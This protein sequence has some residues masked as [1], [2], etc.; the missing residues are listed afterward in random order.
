MT[1]ERAQAAA[2]H[3]VTDPV[4]MRRWLA[5]VPVTREFPPDLTAT[6]R[7]HSSLYVIEMSTAPGCLPCADLWSRLNELRSRYGWR[8]RTV[9]G[10]EAL[11]RSGRLGLPWVGHPVAWVRPQNDP[12]RMIPIAIGTDHAP[13][14]ARNLY[15]SAKMLTGVRPAVAVRAMSKFTGIVGAPARPT[16]KTRR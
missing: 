11:L 10:E 2:V 4:S 9:S 14:L 7:A 3:P 13:N 5:R 12:S 1:R 15:L 8:I 16:T 6:L